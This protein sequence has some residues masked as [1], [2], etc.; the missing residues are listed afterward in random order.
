MPSSL[1]WFEFWGVLGTIGIA[2][3]ALLGQWSSNLNEEYQIAQ[4]N[5]AAFRPPSGQTKGGFPATGPIARIN[6]H[7][8]RREM[9]RQ[10]PR[11]RDRRRRDRIL[12]LTWD[13]VSLPAIGLNPA[14]K[15][16]NWRPGSIFV[17]KGYQRHY[18]PF[19]RW[20][21]RVPLFAPFLRAAR[22]I[23]REMKWLEQHA[24]NGYDPAF[25]RNMAFL[26][27]SAHCIRLL[28]RAR[29]FR[30]LSAAAILLILVGATFAL[31]VLLFSNPFG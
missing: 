19:L 28:Y 12:I 5:L 29:W 11:S 2:A 18:P 23:M 27:N 15:E 4:R 24:P 6:L 31:T 17:L 1:F 21:M 3:Y 20:H 22:A 8:V 10:G 14:W 7:D 9:Q 26:D 25:Y 30:R 13:S 16:W